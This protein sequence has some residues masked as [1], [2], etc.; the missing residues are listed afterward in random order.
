MKK[1]TIEI[2][3]NFIM[4]ELNRKR[5]IRI[6]LPPEYEESKERYPVLYMHDGQNLFDACTAAFGVSWEASGTVDRL[7]NEENF[8]G[9]II[10]GVDNGGEVRCSEYSPWDNEEVKKLLWRL[11]DS[12]YV[13]GEGFQYTDFLVN[14]LKPFIDK[15]YRT[16]SD[17][18]NTAI[19]GSSMGGF[20]SLAGGLKYQEVFSK[21]AA[22]SSAIWFSEDE[23]IKFIETTGKLKDMKIYMDIGTNETSNSE[24]NEFPDIYVNGNKRTYETLRKIGFRDDEV[25][26]VI[27]EGAIHNEVEWA[28]RFPAMLMWIFH[29][30]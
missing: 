2:I 19:S 14:T 20:I 13:G 3:E 24:L 5:T 22:F 23:L 9:V 21:I 30:Y 26:F 15:N 27:D 28:R 11:K 12:P 17:R 8:K 6:Y 29:K 25:K 16:L 7:Y 10:V 1:G 4:P 18:E